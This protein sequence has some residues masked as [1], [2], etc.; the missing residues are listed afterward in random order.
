M[1]TSKIYSYQNKTYNFKCNRFV[2]KDP[3]YL[4]D[5]WAFCKNCDTSIYQHNIFCPLCKR[6]VLFERTRDKMD[7]MRNKYLQDFFGPKNPLTWK[8]KPHTGINWNFKVA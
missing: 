8:L 1:M 6:G 7:T 3:S 4:T 5:D 2:S